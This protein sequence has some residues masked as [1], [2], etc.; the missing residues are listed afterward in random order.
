MQ[1]YTG[2]FMCKPLYMF[3]VGSPPIIRSTNN[4]VYSI[5]HWSTIAAN[6]RDRGGAETVL[7]LTG[8]RCC[9]YSYLCSC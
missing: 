7:H 6:C 5:W 9:K 2:C 3:R 4:Y 8:T 1:L